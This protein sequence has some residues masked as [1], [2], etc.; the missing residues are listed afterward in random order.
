MTVR[1]AEMPIFESAY[2]K[3]YACSERLF[4]RSSYYSDEYEDACIQSAFIGWLLAKG[5]QVEN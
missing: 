1:E 4:R 5:I 2:R 3:E